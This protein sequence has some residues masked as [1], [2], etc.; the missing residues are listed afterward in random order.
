MCKSVRHCK[1][2]ELPGMQVCDSIVAE[3]PTDEQ[4]LNI[5]G[6]V[7]KGGEQANKLIAAYEQAIKAR[8]QDS[9]L[10]QVLL[11]AQTRW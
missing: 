8:P 3:A 6:M 4:V 1:A 10:L 2:R 7:Y 11:F 5:L 9:H